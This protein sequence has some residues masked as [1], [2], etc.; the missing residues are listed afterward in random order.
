MSAMDTCRHSGISIPECA[1]PA[2]LER[3]LDTFAPAQFRIRRTRIHDPLR[4]E[5]VR[6]PHVI[7]PVS[8][9]LNRPA[10]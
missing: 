9:R 8:E 4:L 1:C 7:P 5:E 6:S 2:C 10:L 3:L